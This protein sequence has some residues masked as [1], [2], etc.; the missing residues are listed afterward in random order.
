MPLSEVPLDLALR[1]EA[2]A[3]SG[4]PLSKT[5]TTRGTILLSFLVQ[6]GKNI[7]SLGGTSKVQTVTLR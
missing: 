2:S 7:A 1:S 5:P 3:S 6:E 4:V